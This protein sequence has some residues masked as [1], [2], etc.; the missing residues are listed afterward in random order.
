MKWGR[1]SFIHRI[2]L[3]TRV[4]FSRPR[5]RLLSS[6]RNRNAN[7]IAGSV[8]CDSY[9]S[10]KRKFLWLKY[11]ANLR[12]LILKKAMRPKT[13]KREKCFWDMRLAN[14]FLWPDAAM[15]FSPSVQRVHI[16]AVRWQKV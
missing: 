9:V 4:Y 13:C 10:T 6:M 1:V 2:L 11:Q 7:T 12:D 15:T 8:R 3:G 16:M 14:R 5:K